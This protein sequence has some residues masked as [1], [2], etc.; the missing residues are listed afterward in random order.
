MATR[1][2]S[3]TAARL[4]STSARRFNA[5]SGA[6]STAPVPS[7]LPVAVHHFRRPLPYPVGLQLQ[8]DII[9][10]RL[11]EKARDLEST[12]A[13]QD[14]MLMLGGQ[15]VEYSVRSRELTLSRHPARAPPD[16]HDGPARLVAQP[17][18]AAPRR[19][20]GAARRRRLPHHQAGRTGHVSW[21]WAAGRVPDL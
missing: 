16:V 4:L 1:T 3:R 21:P 14:V 5:C 11:A 13:R 20:K 2:A 15:D 6:A 8:N 7:E 17:G 12:V 19:G 18:H 10:L 9:D